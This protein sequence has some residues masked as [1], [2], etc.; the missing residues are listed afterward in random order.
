MRFIL[1]LILIYLVIAGLNIS[2]QGI[3][4]LSM[5]DRG[6]VAGISYDSN[7]LEMQLM[8][9]EYSHHQLLD[10][11]AYLVEKGRNEMRDVNDYFGKMWRIF[12][13]VFL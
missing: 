1:V 11:Y 13:A 3:N 2:N 7:N 12:K 8:G 10:D 5:E 4:N 6:P 9:K